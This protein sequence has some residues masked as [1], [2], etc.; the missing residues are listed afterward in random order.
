MPSESRVEN[1]L[2]HPVLFTYQVGQYVA[3]KILSPAPPDA[4]RKLGRPKVAIIG[5]GI[6]GVSA[7]A[8]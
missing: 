4:N 7:A 1:P 2:I 8:Q 3:N 6:T 5:A